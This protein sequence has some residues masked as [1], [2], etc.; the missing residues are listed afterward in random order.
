M[1]LC[2]L[3]PFVFNGFFHSLCYIMVLVHFSLLLSVRLAAGTWLSVLRLCDIM[4]LM[5]KSL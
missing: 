5:L 2:V 3:Q 4:V 1:G